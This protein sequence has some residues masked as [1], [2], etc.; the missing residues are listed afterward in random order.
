MLLK[1][2]IEFFEPVV[3]GKEASDTIKRLA[4]I[5]IHETEINNNAIGSNAD[6]LEALATRNPNIAVSIPNTK[7][8]L[9]SAEFINECNRFKFDSKSSIF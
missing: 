3:R 7:P 9:L 6:F 8:I 1:K 2:I 5:K 4:K